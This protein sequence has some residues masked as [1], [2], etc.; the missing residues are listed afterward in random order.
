MHKIF[1]SYVLGAYQNCL[2]KT[3]LLSTHN[4]CF[5]R[6]LRILF[7]LLHTQI[8]RSGLYMDFL[9]HLGKLI[10]FIFQFGMDKDL[11][12]QINY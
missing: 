12:P 10:N 11:W 7:F 9:P 1:L 2:I 5:G 8:W 4:L 3:V 6:E